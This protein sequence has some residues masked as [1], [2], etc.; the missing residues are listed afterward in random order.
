MPAINVARTDTFEIQR[1]KINQIGDQ[2]F[3]I[4]AGG[5]DLAT[6][7]LKLGDGTKTVPSLAF[8]SDGTLGLYK[9]GAKAIGF[10]SGSK[11][12][13]DLR[14][15]SVVSFKDL[16]VQKKSLSTETLSITNPGQN[17][18]PGTYAAISLLGGT[19]L[20]A[21]ADITVD[22]FLGTTLTQGDDFA[23][24]NFTALLVGGTGQDAEISFDVDGIQGSISDAGGGYA[25]NTYTGVNLTNVSGSGSNATADIVVSG[26]VVVAGTIT[27]GGSG[28][29][30]ADGVF[31]GIFLTNGSGNGLTADVTLTAG[32]VTNVV[33]INGGFGYVAGDVLGVDPADIAGDGGSPTGSGFAYTL[34]SVIYDGEVSSVT[35]TAEGTGYSI[36]D[37]LSASQADLGNVGGSGFEYTITSD[38]G[39]PYN[40]EFTSKGEG[41]TIGD[42]LSLGGGIA[43]VSTT[44]AGSIS[45]V[46]ATVTTG[47][48]TVVLSSTTDII[49]GMSLSGN[50][51]QFP[52]TAT[53]V[54]VDSATDITVSDPSTAT[55]AAT[56]T[57]TAPGNSLI[58]TVPDASNISIGFLVTQTGGTGTLGANTVVT[59]V[60]LPT[61]EISISVPPVRAGAVT[62]DFNPAY[63]NPSTNF[64]FRVDVLG[65]IS[66]INIVNDGA[67]YDIG[68]TLTASSTD[69]TQPI[70]IPVTVID[71]DNIIPLAPIPGGTYSV[72]DTVSIDSGE[73]AAIDATVVEVVSSGGNI[74]VLVITG[75]SA[76]SGAT[77]DGTYTAGPNGFAGH[78]YLIN[79]NVG[80]NLTLYSGNTYTFDTSDTTNTGHVFAL[81]SF[82]DGNF[83]P[84]FITNVATSLN[85]STTTISVAST[86]GILPG[87]EVTV[88]SGSGN[89]LAGTKVESVPDGTNIILDTAPLQTGTAVLSFSGTQ[90]TDNVIRDG[91]NALTI[92]ITD[93]TPNL[94]YYCEN[95]PDMGGYDNQEGLL[96]VDLNNPKT[97]GSGLLLTALNITE[98]NVISNQVATGTLNSVN[99][100]GTSLDF[101]GGTVDDITSVTTKTTTLT[102]TTI[103]SDISGDD[104]IDINSGTAVNILTGNFNIGTTIQVVNSTGNITTSGTLKST[105]KISS[106]DIL[107]IINNEISVV[108]GQ[109]LLLNVPTADN[110]LK[111]VSTSAI[112]IPSGDTSQR[113]T[114]ELNGAIRFNTQTNSYE[115]YSETNGT[116]SSLGGV[117]DIDGNTTI[118]AEESVGAN[119]NTL[120]FINDNVNTVRFTPQYQEF[121]NVKKIRSVNVSAPDYDIWRANAQVSLGEY[122]KYRNNIYEVTVAGTTGTS[123]DEPV[124]TSGAV[125]NGTAELTFFVT[126]V[127][128][129]TFEEISE[130][131]IDPLGFTDLVVNNELRFSGN[132]ISSNTN[133]IFITPNAGQKVKIDAPTS[134]VLPV[135]DNNSK[136]NPERGSVRYNTDDLQFEGFN[137]AQWGGLGGVKDIDQDTYIIPETSPNADEDILYFYNGNVNTLQLNSTKLEFRGIDTLES[138]VSNEFN[139]DASI[140]A[141]DF[142]AT[143]LDNTSTTSSFLYTTKEHLD[144]GLSA[145]LTTDSLLKL[146]DQGDIYFNLGFG[147]GV[148]NGVKV[149]DSELKELEIADYK[150]VTKKV[151]LDRGT[152]NSGDAVLYDPATQVSARVYLTAHNTTTGDKEFIEYSVIDN[153]TDIFYTEIGNIVTGEPLVNSAFDF[154]ASNQVRLT[155]TLN[156]ALTTGDDVEVTVVSN[157][158]KR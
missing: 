94:Y 131:R 108:P 115:G 3:N 121:V 100:T 15:T 60:D 23:P 134:L 33:V 111:V 154:N 58:F 74:Q 91:A 72:G 24:G 144:L 151:D 30:G 35:I 156:T 148:Y 38:P 105:T 95:H 28:Y 43:G 78:R 29:A 120:W 10:V 12:I 85:A 82:R 139:F 64:T 87:M 146:T 157:I 49:P 31:T 79:G 56:I 81:S 11:R 39:V 4:S 62:L 65:A 142:L 116:W 57:F 51:G 126:A 18:D 113:P 67:G 107:E 153:G 16:L 136:G 13:V 124:H 59:N 158:T 37:V 97:F 5:S 101:D 17:Y 90:Y 68:D 70:T 55:G 140:I 88:L 106:N 77:I 76:P 19:G 8:T 92:K 34:S 112:V 22:G 122:L 141:F 127:S 152:V 117:R 133:D 44:L 137:G 132:V 1:Q 80:E 129:L 48:T 84:S 9:P 118:L 149:F 110:Q 53:V 21:T 75:A 143:V 130:V 52:E 7:N 145:G 73:G 147:T 155:F 50:S 86:S 2:I 109:D 128:S 6:G 41:Y 20:N 14:E 32:V 123:G 102:A 98:T 61:N 69:L 27:N 138:S 36:G 104:K 96:T 125:T 114:T 89:L 71:V 45:N 26:N 47:S 46:S 150:V 119:D 99:C 93:T 54:S 66:E 135:G 42:V 103:Q 25:P 40:V 83:T 63:G